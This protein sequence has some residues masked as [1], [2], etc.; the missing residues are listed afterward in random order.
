MKRIILLFSIILISGCRPDKKPLPY[1][2]ESYQVG[3]YIAFHYPGKGDKKHIPEKKYLTLFN[4]NS[5][6]L[7][8]DDNLDF[9][10]IIKGKLMQK[11]GTVYFYEQKLSGKYQNTSIELID[12]KE[13]KGKL[14][15]YL[16]K[17]EFGYL[18]FERLLTSDSTGL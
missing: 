5:F 3:D 14:L 12:Y 18:S 11:N 16:G 9:K 1:E 13:N 2:L 10:E 17:K 8:L 6:I 7:A 15:I 4:D